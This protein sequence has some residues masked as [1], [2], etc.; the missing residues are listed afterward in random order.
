MI[1]S[2]TSGGGDFSGSRPGGRAPISALLYW[3]WTHP[4]DAPGGREMRGAKWLSAFLVVVLVAP[5]WLVPLA[6]L[7]QTP[8]QAPPP[9]T[10]QPASPTTLQP[11]PP[12]TLQPA[13]PTTLQPPPPPPGPPPPPPP[14]SLQ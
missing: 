2:A 14:T 13:P 9:T 4:P 5:G 1:A 3:R 7:A 6:A 11:A 10:I 12:T 8:T